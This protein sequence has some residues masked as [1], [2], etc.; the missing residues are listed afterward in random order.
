M[1]DLKMKKKSS[2]EL[3]A[4]VYKQQAGVAAEICSGFIHTVVVLCVS[5]EYIFV[6]TKIIVDA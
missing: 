2:F 3:P 6:V 4:T 5:L 1:S